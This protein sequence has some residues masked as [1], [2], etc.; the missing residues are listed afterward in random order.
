MY[1]VV[2][3]HSPSVLDPSAFFS[4]V[5]RKGTLAQCI[6]RSRFRRTPEVGN[7][8]VYWDAGTTGVTIVVRDG[9]N[10]Y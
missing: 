3:V 9:T 2:V 7:D 4:G 8:V 6:A 10:A 1:A 5:P